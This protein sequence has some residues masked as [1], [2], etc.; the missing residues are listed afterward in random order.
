M[1]ESVCFSVI[2]GNGLGRSFSPSSNSSWC[3]CST[4][5]CGSRR[6]PSSDKVRASPACP[7]TTRR[8]TWLLAADHSGVNL[9]GH[10]QVEPLFLRLPRASPCAPHRL[11]DRRF[12]CERPQLHIIST[13]G[14]S[15]RPYAESE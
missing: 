15:V 11:A 12:K 10:D 7:R 9:G 4:Y 5:P 1:P 14:A 13:T 6:K 3:I 8:G 2:F